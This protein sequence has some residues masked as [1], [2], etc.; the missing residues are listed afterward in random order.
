M[1]AIPEA[2]CSRSQGKRSV[3]IQRNPHPNTADLNAIPFSDPVSLRYTHKNNNIK[4]ITTPKI[5]NMPGP[6]GYTYCSLPSTAIS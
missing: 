2:A 6:V 3:A 4:N 1:E 5:K